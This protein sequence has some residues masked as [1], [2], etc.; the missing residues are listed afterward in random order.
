MIALFKQ[1][2]QIFLV[3]ILYYL[4]TEIV[5]FLWVDF[6]FLP[7]DLVIDL[8]IALAISSFIFLI[9][10][11]KWSIIYLSIIYFLIVSLFLI[12]ATMYSV[13]YDL[14]TLQQLSLIGE[15]TDVINA[16][17]LSIWSI[18]I[19]IGLLAFYFVSMRY[20]YKYLKKTEEYIPNY[21][22]KGLASFFSTILFVIGFFMIPMDS[23]HSF[24]A[25]ANVTTFKRSSFE[26]YG[27][28]G[29]YTKEIE[30]II[31]QNN[32]NFTAD[33]PVDYSQPTD[34]YNL[35][36]GKNVIS[37]LLESVQP[38]AINETLTPNL[39][40]LTQEGLYFENSYSENKTNVSEMIAT[41]GNYPTI[42]LDAENYTYDFSYSLPSILKAQGYVTS[43][44]HDNVATFYDRGLLM[45]QLG[46]DNVYLHEEMFPDQE[47][48]NWNGNY[49]LDSITM[50]QMLPN[51][52]TTDG[53][54]YSA[55]A[56]MVTH[57]PYDYGLT[58]KAL[59]EELGYFDAIDQAEADGLWTNILAG[60]EVEDVMRIRHYQAAVMN[61][62][63]AIG[64]MLDQLK[65]QNLLDD[66]IIVLYGDHNVYY[67]DL[68]L[69]IF[70]DED[71]S[72][73]NMEMYH[74]FFCIY[75]PVLT[76][77]YLERT[78]A[79]NTT[80]SK[81]VTPYNIVPTLMDLLGI[82]YDQNIYMGSSIFS[83]QEDVFY[84]IKMTGFFNFNMY[85]DDGI[86]IAY[87]KEEYTEQQYLDF[88]AQCDLLK[89][90]IGYVNKLYVDTKAAR[91]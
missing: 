2:S 84:S 20:L 52:T 33:I 87:Y 59:F 14:F 88:I 3:F 86:E 58:N 34:Y 49:T 60:G 68:Y 1:K 75:N 32:P 63:V 40:Q 53:P 23:I 17:L 80:I 79:E 29:Y 69:K 65:E 51:L 8:V 45:P 50:E 28:L 48:W 56:T 10:S 70:A 24:L 74:N 30:D 47:I 15:A 89:T 18:L 77:T 64:M 4:I 12:N 11:H 35:L 76:E 21:Y 67:H 90:K 43:Y 78:G 41:I 61:T 83:D 7:Q 25:D 72:Y 16:D 91:E 27:I 37:I 6:S 36:E 31:E 85:S 62:D 22:A 73:Y 57:G 5:T 13:Y 9:R 71:N 44:F 66:T 82:E 39:Y 26:Q 46:F 55:W 81:F 19:A 42:G 54:F 38:F